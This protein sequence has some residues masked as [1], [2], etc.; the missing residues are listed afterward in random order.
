MGGAWPGAQ[1]LG[2]FGEKNWRVF[3]ISGMAGP[4]N[5]KFDMQVEVNH[6]SKMAD[7]GDFIIRGVAHSRAPK[8]EGKFGEKWGVF[9]SQ[10]WLVRLT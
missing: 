9:V 10:E 1:K 3:C 5:F 2:K 7:F 8:L 4:I 6:I